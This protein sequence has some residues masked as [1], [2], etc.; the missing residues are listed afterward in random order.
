MLLGVSLAGE[1]RGELAGILRRLREFLL[2]F[3]AGCAKV[4]DG[5]A[6][7]VGVGAIDVAGDFISSELVEVKLAVEGSEVGVDLPDVVS[8]KV[9]TPVLSGLARTGVRAFRKSV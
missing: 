6:A 9:N 4:P 2:I 8:V 7:E 1:L 5:G 3:R